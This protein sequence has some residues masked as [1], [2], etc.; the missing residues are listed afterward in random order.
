MSN[1][2][3]RIAI[4]DPSGQGGI[5]HYTYE[6]AQHLALMGSDITLVT[7]ENY[8]LKHLPRG[9]NIVFLFKK[10]W[11]KR[12]AL[13][14]IVPVRWQSAHH[15]ERAFQNGARARAKIT[16]SL[17][18]NIRLRITSLKSSIFFIRKRPHLI[19]YQW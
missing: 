3:L 8:E 13:S 11:I 2:R 4:Y 15:K 16:L 18:R 5:C 12:L 9:F 19:H 1:R 7:T 6:L 14:L 10:S 17:V